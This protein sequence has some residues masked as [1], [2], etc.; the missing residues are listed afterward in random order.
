M[1]YCTGVHT[2][3]RNGPVVPCLVRKGSQ[4]LMQKAVLPGLVFCLLVSCNTSTAQGNSTRE[5]WDHILGVSGFAKSGIDRLNNPKFRCQVIGLGGTTMTVDPWGFAGHRPPLTDQ[6]SLNHKPSLGYEFWWDNTG[7]RYN[8]FLINAGYGASLDPGMITAFAQHLDI[9]TGVLKTDVTLTVAGT[10]FTSSREAFVTPDGTVVIRVQDNGAPSPLR[11]NVAI[12]ETVEWFGTYYAGEEDSFTRNVAG[13][14]NRSDGATGGVVAVSRPNTS[15]CAVAVAVEASSPVTVS[16]KSD[17][18]GETAANGTTTFYLVPASSFNPATPTVPWDHA[19]RQASAA[20][21]AGYAAL[22]QQTADW[23]REFLGK[24]RVSV[25]DDTVSQLYAQS[26]FYHGVYFGNTAIPPGCFGTDIYGFFGAVCPEYD[27]NFSS[28]A[29]AY[30]GHL[31]ETK[32]IACLG[33]FRAAK[34]QGTG[35]EGR[36]AS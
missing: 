4:T 23:W 31:D 1:M 32:N 12:N 22:K 11:L 19:W 20:R 16:A 28:F 7:H 29:M 15:D 3:G 17:I 21:N 33:V 2:P 36:K 13:T 34:V 5:A 27:L 9:R 10:Q 14:S 24:S 6:N 35:Y 26:L 25:P 30:T 18:Y 8:P